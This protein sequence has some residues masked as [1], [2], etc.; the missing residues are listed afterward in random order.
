MVRSWLCVCRGWPFSR[1]S[2]A[3]TSA[4]TISVTT[5]RTA[6][7]AALCMWDWICCRIVF[8]SCSCSFPWLNCILIVLKPPYDTCVFFTLPHGSSLQTPFAPSFATLRNGYG[9]DD[10]ALQVDAPLPDPNE[11]RRLG[12]L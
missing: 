5:P 7:C 1:P 2:L 3:V 11:R 12:N 6:S 4:S 9:T 8:R 10:K